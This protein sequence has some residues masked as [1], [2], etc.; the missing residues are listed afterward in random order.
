MSK[1]DVEAWMVAVMSS[2]PSRGH[3][4]RVDTSRRCYFVK[5]GDGAAKIGDRI[6][7]VGH[8]ERESI[9]ISRQLVRL[10]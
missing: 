5:N 4:A 9:V 2:G 3:G 7:R 1:G 8:N 6:V 10:I